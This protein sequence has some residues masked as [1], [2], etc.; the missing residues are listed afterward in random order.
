MYINKK[1]YDKLEDIILYESEQKAKTLERIQKMIDEINNNNN[2]YNG[3]Y[4]QEVTGGYMIKGNHY[5]IPMAK[6]CYTLSEVII[7]LRYMICMD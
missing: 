7:H 2:S 1:L 6:F 5:F 4:L 3:L